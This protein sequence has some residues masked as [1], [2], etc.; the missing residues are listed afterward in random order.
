MGQYYRVLLK[1]E[2]KHYKVYNRSVIIDGKKEFT[3]PKLMEHSWWLNPFV[4]AICEQLYQ[5]PAKIVWLGDYSDTFMQDYPKGFHGLSQKQVAYF[6]KIVWGKKDR[7]KAIPATDFTLEGKY[8]VNHTQKEYVNCSEFFN[9]S[10]MHTKYDCDWCIHPLPLLTC[11]G[12][13]CGSGDYRYE[14]SAS[15]TELVGEWAFD[16]ISIEDT[17]PMDYDEIYPIFQE[18]GWEDEQ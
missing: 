8:L 4:N 17:P 18:R 11:I 3:F 7:S 16:C 10:V 12:N 1:E 13:G 15:T 6:D 5:S 9:N 2:N 14:T